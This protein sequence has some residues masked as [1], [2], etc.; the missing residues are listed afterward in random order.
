MEAKTHTLSS[1]A[2]SKFM[3]KL[4]ALTQDNTMPIQQVRLLLALY[5]YGQ[6]G[7][8]GLS[9]HTGVAPQSNTRNIAKLG[10]GEKMKDGLGLVESYE[11]PIDRR[12]KMVRLTPKGHALIRSALE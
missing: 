12:H 8:L 2:V 4:C 11:D 5:T 7:Q 1:A 9:E 6:I 10:P 3:E